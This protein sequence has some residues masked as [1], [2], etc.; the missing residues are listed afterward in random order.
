MSQTAFDLLSAALTGRQMIEASAGT[1]KTYTLV[2]LCLRLLV[3][4]QLKIE[5]IL[6]VTFT[7]AATQELLTRLRLRLKEALACLV[8]GESADPFLRAWLLP[9]RTEPAVEQVL[10]VALRDLDLARISTIHAFCQWALSR[11]P[12]RSAQPLQMAVISDQRLLLSQAIED[13]WRKQMY[14]AEPERVMPILMANWSPE[15][16]LNQALP[17]LGQTDLRLL[18]EPEQTTEQLAQT[19]REVHADFSEYYAQAQALWHRER[20]EILAE[21]AQFKGKSFQLRH[22]EGRASALDGYFAEPEP[23]LP[24]DS[25]KLNYFAR[26]VIAAQQTTFQPSHVFFEMVEALRASALVW[27]EV[28]QACRQRWLFQFAQAVRAQL[29]RGKKARQ[30]LSFDDLLSHLHQALVDPIQGKALAQAL[31]EEIPVALID[32]FQD[33]DGLQAAIFNLIYPDSNADG[34]LFLIGDPKQAIYGFRGADIQTYLKMR[35]DLPSASVH[36]LNTNFRSQAG[37][38]SALETLFDCEQPFADPAIDFVSV[39][40]G[41]SPEEWQVPPAK[42]S[43]DAPLEIAWIPTLPDQKPWSKEKLSALLPGA[44]ARAVRETLQAGYRLRDGQGKP[45]Q[46]RPLQAQDVAVL[47]R[48][49]AQ[50]QDIR[51]ALQKEGIPCVL[52]AQESVFQTPEAS[53]LVV[54]LAAVLQPSSR[55]AVL[56]ALAS[57]LVGLSAHEIYLLQ[58]ES[59]HSDHSDGNDPRTQRQRWEYWLTHFH[60]ARQNWLE[61][62]FTRMWQEWV[63]SQGLYRRL[64]RQPEGE[65]QV[66]HLRHLSELL[67]N[68][69][70]HH[71]PSL[72]ALL[73]WLLREQQ[74]GRLDQENLLLQLETDRQAVQILTIH[75]SKGLEFPVV[76]C[77]Y[78]W[79]GK[80]IAA[81]APLSARDPQTRQSLL[82]LGSEQLEQRALQRQQE[83]LQEDLRLAYVALTRA[84][85]KV[86]LA[87][88]WINQI[89]CAAL[90]HLIPAGS[91]EALFQHLQAKADQSRGQW[92]IQTLEFQ[93]G[94]QPA[95]PGPEQPEPLYLQ[96]PPRIPPAHLARSFSSLQAQFEA[97]V[98]AGLLLPVLNLEQQDEAEPE[99]APDLLTGSGLPSTAPSSEGPLM[100]FPRGGRHGTF[101]HLLLETLLPQSALAQAQ[102]LSEAV[103]TALA[104]HGYGPEWQTPVADALTQIWQTPLFAAQDAAGFAL[105]DLSPAKRLHEWA[106]QFPI[107]QPLRSQALMQVLQSVP[108]WAH[109]PDLLDRPLRGQFKGVIDLVCEHQGRY[110]VVDYKSNWLGNRYSD[111]RAEALEVAL[112]QHLYPLQYHLYLVALHR[113]LRYRLPDYVPERHLG[114]ALVLFLRGM[115]PDLPGNGVC[116][117]APDPALILTLSELFGAE[118]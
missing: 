12:L 36:S 45:L 55:S 27:D 25:D 8:S 117:E 95:R 73:T 52:Y 81:K 58:T 57:P 90:G 63:S 26:D 75:R 101:L 108:R 84:R 107:A 22:L 111:Y 43:E 92:R 34:P 76:F 4:R 28:A 118:T 105:Q 31:R 113:Y 94:A 41:S 89:D 79:D 2:N 96:A 114:G 106:F 54:F 86:W 29:Q 35:E 109:L 19:W 99:G 87:W 32:E 38:L 104:R 42:A 14:L 16:L 49:H 78:L 18:P 74:A 60:L 80:K 77:P 47:V 9:L 97:G 115:T 3:E 11:F 46:L 48:T 17:L 59:S 53:A 21:A 85:Y 30:Q 69:A 10:R 13:F 70:Q 1:G 100:D 15:C 65:R 44:V 40:A 50:G 51:E 93:R 68:Y 102:S 37:L 98:E 5:A 83:A 66:T 71:H 82:D 110:Y 23:H 91:G 20:S 33:T 88:G 64:L 116:F 103:K 112:V 39:A 7:E 6:I 67:Q 61:H 62:G 72:Q 56:Q 24:S